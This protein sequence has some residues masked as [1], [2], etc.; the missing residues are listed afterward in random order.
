MRRDYD[1]RQWQIYRWIY[2][3]LTE[4][5]DAHIARILKA[6]EEAGLEENT[7]VVF[8]SDHGNMDA[9]HRLA[10]KSFFY[11]EAARVPFLMKYKGTIPAKR[12]D[13]EHFVSTGL[14]ILPTLCDYAGIQ[15]PKTLM[16][17][18]LRRI[19][20]AKQVS[21]WRRYVVSENHSGRMLRSDRFKYC[22]YKSGTPR[23]SLVDMK[24]DPGEMKNLASLPGYE[25]TLEEHRRYLDEWIEE[26]KDE[27]AKKFVIRDSKT[28]VT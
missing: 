9:S 21:N 4:Q 18:S 10:S 14:D 5:V 11:D 1:Q 28:A 25:K 3:R 27:D 16:G 6:L 20:E 23:E 13:R 15:P 17:K 24:K 12:V 2:C 19:A 22:L 7:L 8:T 26:S